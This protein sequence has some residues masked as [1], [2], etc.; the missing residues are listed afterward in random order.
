M[1]IFIHNAAGPYTNEMVNSTQFTRT[2]THRGNLKVRVKSA[3]SGT[4]LNTLFRNSDNIYVQK[5]NSTAAN[6]W[7]L[8]QRIWVKV[9]PE[10]QDEFSRTYGVEGWRLVWDPEI[11]FTKSDNGVQNF[12]IPSW[13]RKDLCETVGCWRNEL[14][15]AIGSTSRKWWL[16]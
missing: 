15:W 1:A 8:I 3:E 13:C 6:D 11:V 10:D 7:K 9:N 12:T 5:D 2:G 16:Y 4:N 14:G